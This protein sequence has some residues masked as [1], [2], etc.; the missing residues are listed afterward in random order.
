MTNEFDL[1]LNSFSDNGNIEH[2][3]TQQYD[4]NDFEIYFDR[5]TLLEHLSHLEE[6]NLFKIHLV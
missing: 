5:F 1:E 6:D 4:D 2:L 3:D